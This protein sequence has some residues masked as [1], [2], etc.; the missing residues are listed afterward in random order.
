MARVTVLTVNYNT[1]RFIELCLKSIHA[2][3]IMPHRVIVV[4]NGSTDGSMEYLRALA[5]SQKI[6]LVARKTPLSASEHGRALDHVLYQSGLIKTP[7]VCTID[8]DAYVAKK[9]WLQELDRQRGGHFAVGYEHF[10]D[11]HYLHP[12]CMLMDHKELIHMGKPTFALTKKNGQFFDTGVIVSQTALRTGRKLV[13]GRGLESMVPH[14]W[15]ATRIQRI[16]KDEMLDGRITPAAFSTE[17][18][19]WFARPDVANIMSI[20]YT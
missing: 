5:R 18:N 17:N 19:K 14:R 13:G 3:S 2:N 7:L 6:H 8:S 15:C 9:G 1:R 20:K 16:G 10:R 11:A 12:A 4:D